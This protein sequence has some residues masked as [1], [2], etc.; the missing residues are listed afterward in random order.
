MFTWRLVTSWKLLSLRSTD[1]LTSGA[2][3]NCGKIIHVV[4]EGFEPSSGVLP[5]VCCQ[6]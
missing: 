3:E 4:A 5:L 6:L 2:S 1:D